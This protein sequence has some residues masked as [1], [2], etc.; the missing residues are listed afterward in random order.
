MEQ[1]WADVIEAKLSIA[2]V[3][4]KEERRNSVILG[5]VPI[6]VISNIRVLFLAIALCRGI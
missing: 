6:T 1:I 5:A 3:I 2:T 4:A